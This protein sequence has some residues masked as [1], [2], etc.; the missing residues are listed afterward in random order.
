MV[1]CG[2]SS[3]PDTEVKQADAGQ[4]LNHSDTAH[5]V[6]MNQ[7]KLCHQDIYN[8]FVETGMGKSF[9]HASKEKS[10]AKFDQHTVIYDKFKDF[11]YHP[12]WDKDSLK[13]MEFRLQ[14]KDTIFKRVEKV[15]YI[16]GSGQHTNS[17]IYNT[18]GY[19][20]QMPMTYYTQKGKWDFPPGFENGFNTRFSRKI[21]LECMSCHNSLP[22]FVEGSENKFN[23]LPEGVSCERCHG[24]GSIH[25]QQRATGVKIDTSKYID[26]S[27]VNPGKLPIDLQFDVCQRCHLQGNSVL[28]EGKSFFDF[29]PGMKLSDYMT[30]FLPRYKNADDQFI[31]ASHS[32]RLKQSQCFIKSYKP[33]TDSKSLHPYKNSL[34]CVT[35][36]NPHVS[37]K[38]TGKEIFNNA[39][40]NCH[41]PATPN[42]LCTE[43]ENLR[44]KVQ[45]NCVSCH[46]PQSGSIDIP[47]VS[48]HD[49]FIRKPMKKEEVEKV[50]EFIGLY[51]VNEKNP[52]NYTKAK[53]YIQQYDK[54]EYN[55]VYL[56][57]AQV[58]L[59][60][61]TPEELTQN[62]ELLV[63][64]YFIRLD[65]AK[66][67]S[68][69]NQIGKENVLSSL[70]TK[71]SWDN[72]HAWTLYRIG[73]AYNSSGNITDAYTFYK[74]ADEL[75]P[76]NPEFKNKLGAALMAQQKIPQAI[77]IFESILKEDP[78]FIQAINNLGYANLVSGNVQKAEELYNKALKLDPDYESLLMNMAG[79]NIY[80][81]N[82]KEAETILKRVVKK[83]PQNK[84][85]IQVLEQL[86][87]YK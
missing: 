22:A 19:L 57:S 67:L 6:G 64:L 28:K 52:G 72:A 37:V 2:N 56:D 53:A 27:I 79:L 38:T 30:T 48:V 45:D 34:T 32:D 20:H 51:A 15:D 24:P 10:S 18:N 1:Y 16:V 78:K 9:E 85:A 73:E 12:F 23:A 25:V 84:Q 60:D 83:N 63:H 39:C 31:M 26:Y 54:F 80:K 33:E 17:H 4:Y 42:G 58:Y 77:V 50:K 66:I 36:H 41:S 46:M 44:M 65:Y 35:C 43:K 75:A 14:G 76:Y 71:K 29:K 11:Y 61:K 81:K 3:E 13:I 55:P 47:H 69:V 40:K 5:Y 82:Y 62:F 8:S 87:S 7:C 21:G 68:Y 70:L 59:S 86:K 74:K 49:H